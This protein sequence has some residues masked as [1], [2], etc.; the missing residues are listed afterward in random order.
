[1]A[2]TRP[3]FLRWATAVLLLAAC[4][5]LFMLTAVPPGLA[6]DEIL[7]ADIAA[8]IRQG[9]HAFFFR[10]GYGHEPLYHYWAAPFAPLIGDNALAIRLPSVFLGMLLLAGSLR[11]AKRH[12]GWRTAVFTGIGLAINWWPIIFSRIGI[13]PIAAP[14]VLLAVAWFWPKKPWLAGLF[15]GLSL[16]TYTPTQLFWAWPLLFTAVLLLAQPTQWR[17]Q[18]A[19]TAQLLATAVLVAAP[20]Y[21]TWRAD[22]SLLQRVDQ[23]AGPLQ[24]LQAGDPQPILHAL[25]ATL[26]VFS[27]TGDPRST[28]GLAQRPLFDPFTAVLFYAGLL[29]LG[30]RWRN[31]THALLLSWLAVGLLPSI[32]T[33]QSPSLIRLIGALPVVYLLPAIAADAGLTAV[34]K[35]SRR[36]WLQ[37]IG[38]LVL[39][40]LA[41]FQ[42]A[43][44]WQTGFVAWPQAVETRL[45]HYQATFWQMA[46]HWRTDPVEPLLVLDPFF[47]PIDADSLR[48]SAGQPLAARWIE[49]AGMVYPA[50]QTNGRVYLPEYAPLSPTLSAWLNWPAEPLYRSQT[51][52]SFAVYPLPDLPPV[53]PLSTAVSFAGLI[54]LQGYEAVTATDNALY[55]V[56]WWQVERPLP[57]DLTIFV[58][59]LD[60]NGQ[61]I[62]QHDGFDAGPTTLQ[63]GDYFLQLHTLPQPEGPRPWQW[64]IGLYTANNGQRLLTTHNQ[65]DRF[66][67]E[68]T[69]LFGDGS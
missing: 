53:T 58:H 18:L 30:R 33:P 64:Q 47:E 2:Q 55:L 65:A 43:R 61:L 63:P 10:E 68:T 42:A 34:A 66:S 16:Y 46:S 31:P 57:A 6:Q 26:G 15:L 39:L 11:W 69:N 52:P 17:Q 13:R 62:S 3:S 14:L 40:S 67:L 32:L 50:G 49:P 1:M 27:F 44:T 28:Y 59:V 56:S 4:F 24:A 5:R 37:S 12:F 20:L 9:E 23:L 36:R 35:S 38:W 25:A 45:N 54:S 60:P 29:W 7:D 22:P 21:L 41:L 51:A 19:Q 48:R 8:L